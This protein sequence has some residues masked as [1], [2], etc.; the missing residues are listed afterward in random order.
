[1]KWIIALAALAGAAWGQLSFVNEIVLDA[2]PAEV[3]KVF[4][5]PEGYKLLDVDQA[6]I[7]M[8]VGGLTRTRYGNGPMGDEETIYTRV[9]A[10]EP[11]RMLA[12][13]LEGVPKS[14]PFKEAW[15]GTWSVTT[16]TAL[17]G[18]RTLLRIATLGYR[19]DPE[20]RQ[21]R[22]FFEKGNQGKLEDLQKYFKERER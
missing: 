18:G 16:F 22:E 21:M 6:E 20:S 19:D 4:S 3:W 14:L 15:K 7:D 8:R 10:Y 1:M 9:L 13:A 12:T 11:E 5:T 17:E 2:T